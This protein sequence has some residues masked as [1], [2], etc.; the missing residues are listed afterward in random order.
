MNSEIMS[1]NSQVQLNIIISN[2]EFH[3]SSFCKKINITYNIYIY[4]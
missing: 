4:V 2:Y 3:Q 1:V